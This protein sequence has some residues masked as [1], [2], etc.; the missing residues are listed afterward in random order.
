VVTGIISVVSALIVYWLNRKV[1]QEADKAAQ[2]QSKLND[3]NTAI[4]KGD[5]T[6]VNSRIELL[7]NRLQDIDGSDTSG[8]GSREDGTK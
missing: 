7:V 2:L 5:E 3:I 1:K 6:S 8:Q 4:V